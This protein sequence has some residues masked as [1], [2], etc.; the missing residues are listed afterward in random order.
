MKTFALAAL[1]AIA[2]FAPGAQAQALTGIW[3]T[4]KQILEQLGPGDLGRLR[5]ASSQ[6][7]ALVDRFVN[8]LV[9]QGR[10]VCAVND[11]VCREGTDT[12][13]LVLNQGPDRTLRDW[14][15]GRFEKK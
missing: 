14:G 9:A 15:R 11:P 12:R 8:E 4:D 3:D 7:R 10:L 1:M 2:A 13:H 5:G 6:N